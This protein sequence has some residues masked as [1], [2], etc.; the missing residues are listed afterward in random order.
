M[1]AVFSKMSEDNYILDEKSMTD[2]NKKELN[3]ARKCFMIQDMLGRPTK[4]FNLLIHNDQGQ[5][6]KYSDDITD[7]LTK[8]SSLWVEHGD[9]CCGW[10]IMFAIKASV[11]KENDRN[12]FMFC[13]VGTEPF[14]IDGVCIDPFMYYTWS[15]GK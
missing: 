13:N 8:L 2:E 1:P 10:N 7:I 9:N 15:Q 12:F 14:K 6:L 3:V 11:V 5:L 4:K